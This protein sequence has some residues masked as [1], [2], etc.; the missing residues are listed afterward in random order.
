MDKLE[1]YLDQ[2]CWGVG[3]P[4]SLR[5]HIREELREHLQDA[6]GAYRAAGATEEEAL[7]RALADFGGPEQVRSELEAT[8]GHRL[9]AVVVD[10]ALQW[11][12]TTMRAKWLWTTWAH[13]AL[14]GV[15]AL[16]V[17]FIVSSMVMVMP[18]CREIVQTEWPDPGGSG[19]D[20][21]L[22][23]AAS[24]V[25]G[26][27]TT[28]E[29]VAWWVIPLAVAW[30][31]FEWRWRSEH[32]VFIRLAAMGTAALGLMVVV[33][34]TS[35]AMVVPLTMVAPAIRLRP[36]EPIVRETVARIDTALQELESALAKKDWDA[37]ARAGHAAY[38][39]MRGLAYMGAAA[40]TLRALHDQTD[41]DALRAEL[42]SANESLSEARHAI[43][44]KNETR[45]RAAL[46]KFHAR[47]RQAAG[48]VTRPVQ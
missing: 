18:K 27:A 40:P 21:F 14:A 25:Q 37:M 4:R 26:L 29:Y 7:A 41:V 22:A 31:L 11:K 17:F 33:I 3:G 24:F 6:A 45:L 30:V 5:Q 8:H 36:P 10:K 20:D 42:K 15:I 12:E 39:E 1:R 43:R 9:M 32:K 46:E 19:A 13:L 35:T 23:W 44:D 28:I 34:L 48:P 38:H 47:Y 16:E 2:V